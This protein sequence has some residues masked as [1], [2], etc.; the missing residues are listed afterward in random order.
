MTPQH[1]SKP[2]IA[3]K[4]SRIEDYWKKKS[5]HK[6]SNLVDRTIISLEIHI[7]FY[8]FSFCDEIIFFL[9]IK[10]LFF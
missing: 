6:F 5:P 1:H 4:N 10:D 7:T 8:V 3:K 2:I 9:D